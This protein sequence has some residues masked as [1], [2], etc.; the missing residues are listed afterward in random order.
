VYRHVCDPEVID[1]IAA[2]GRPSVDLSTE[3]IPG[4]V[5]R[6][7]CMETRGYHRDIGTPQSLRRARAAF[8]ARRHAPA[9]A[10]FA[11]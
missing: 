10:E 2:I 4:F 6:I 3:I 7:S 1:A 8:G 5:G 11:T 9:T